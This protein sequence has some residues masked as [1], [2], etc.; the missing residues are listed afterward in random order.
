MEELKIAETKGLADVY[1][2][3]LCEST[4]VAAYSLEEAKN[5]YKELTGLEDEDLYS[6]DELEIV[7]DDYMV[8]EDDSMNGMISVGDIIDQ[9][10]VGGPFIVF[11]SDL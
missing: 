5:W 8:Y 10:W 7:S 11:T 6:D 4:A 2:Y 9:R 1:A 3:Q